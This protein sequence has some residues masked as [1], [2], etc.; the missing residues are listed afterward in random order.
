MSV[1]SPSRLVRYFFVLRF[2]LGVDCPLNFCS[3]V[4]P[5]FFVRVQLGSRQAL[6]AIMRRFLVRSVQG[7]AR[8]LKS[9][10]W[11]RWLCRHPWRIVS[12]GLIF[13]GG[14]LCDQIGYATAWVARA[15]DGVLASLSEQP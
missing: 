2:E 7:C 4:D 15:L 3:F 12:F 6:Q 11:L 8:L 9:W 1:D 14:P 5:L 10:I 13:A